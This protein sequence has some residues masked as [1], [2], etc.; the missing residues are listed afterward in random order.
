MVAKNESVRGRA[1]PS[2]ENRVANSLHAS[3]DRDHAPT[4]APSAPSG[5]AILA[6]GY[7]DVAGHRRCFVASIDYKIVPLGFSQNG[8]IDG[9]TEQNIIVT[10]TQRR[11]E[12]R[13][14]F[15]A[16]L[17]GGVPGPGPQ[18]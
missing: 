4:V 9:L 15:L 16:L 6:P 14:I 8:F 13:G 17:S 10:C 5:Q 7:R 2:D 11:S 18:G 12:I 3:K 1:R